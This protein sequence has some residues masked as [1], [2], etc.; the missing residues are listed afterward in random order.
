MSDIAWK[1]FLCRNFTISSADYSPASLFPILFL[2]KKSSPPRLIAHLAH[3]IRN[4]LIDRIQVLGDVFDR[5]PQPDKIIRIL[6]SLPY[7][8][9]VDYVLGNHD[10]LWMGAA[11]GNK[12]LIAEA[13]RITCRYD[14]FEFLERLSIDT[15][16]LTAFAEKTY[17]PDK[18]TGNFKATN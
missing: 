1:M 3:A 17:P 11:S 7:R 13:M 16:L 5:G 2:K 18:V 10:I 15:S 6:S 9:I 8:R 4:V 14:H 12:S